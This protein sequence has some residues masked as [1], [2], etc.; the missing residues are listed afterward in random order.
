MSKFRKT[1]AATVAEDLRKF[2]T[3]L[4]GKDISRWEKSAA[5]GMLNEYLDEIFGEDGFGT[6]GQ[7]D[8]R[9]DHRT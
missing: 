8:P 2:A 9:G 4:E 5:A 3:W 6:E 1:T 7:C